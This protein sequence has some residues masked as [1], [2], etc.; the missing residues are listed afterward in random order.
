MEIVISKNGIKYTHQKLETLCKAICLR[1][2]ISYKEYKL[3]YDTVMIYNI[4]DVLSF[5]IL[6][7]YLKELCWE[8]DI[9]VVDL[10]KIREK[11]KKDRIMD[12]TGKI[13]Y[14]DDMIELGMAIAKY[15]NLKFLDYKR[16]GNDSL[17][18]KFRKGL[19]KYTYS[20]SV[21]Y[22]SNEVDSYVNGNYNLYHHPQL[23]KE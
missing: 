5:V 12:K 19:E 1:K 23:V 11:H 8:Y 2:N 10:D 7:D 3:K 15:Y 4:D 9:E 6:F 14:S 20:V 21:R 22:F 16:Y 17:T 13:F 18:F